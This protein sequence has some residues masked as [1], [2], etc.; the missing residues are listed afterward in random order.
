MGGSML[1]SFVQQEPFYTAQNIKVLVPK[2]AMTT[3]MK[4]YYCLCIEANKHK[5]STFGREANYTFDSLLVPGINELPGYIN[6]Y[7]TDTVPLK[8]NPLSGALELNTTNW[9]WF[10]IAELF[11]VFTSKEE[12]ALNRTDGNT[13]FISSTRFSNG[14]SRY[15][16]DEPAV[17]ANTITIARNGSIGSAFYQPQPYCA[18][19]DDVRI[20]EPKFNM[21]KYTALFLITILETE[22]YRY[23]YGRKFGT[24]RM[25]E[26]K[27]KLPVNS[28]G[29]P[30]WKFMENYIKS[31]PYSQEV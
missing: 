26:T 9:Q 11:N 20:F 30:D 16:A 31:L 21:N 18:S 10:S 12:N 29:T 2:T 1:A 6:K 17:S 4:L 14:V 5:F 7:N 19:P 27:I 25:R 22:K 3:A 8:K 13:P 24:K 15:V 28:S 23:A